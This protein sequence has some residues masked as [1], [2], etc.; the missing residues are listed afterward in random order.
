MKATDDVWAMH[1]T[2]GWVAGT[3]SSGSSTQEECTVSIGPQT[4]I[5]I[6]REGVTL[7]ND[8]LEDT[9]DNLVSLTFLNEPC[10]LYTLQRRYDIHKIYTLNGVFLISV[11][12]FLYNLP[13]YFYSMHIGESI[14]ATRCIQ[15]CAS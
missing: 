9:S 7:R 5:T 10:I 6:N 13:Y 8:E 15:R 2:Q 12:T 11:P 14:P 4:S 3:I 1:P